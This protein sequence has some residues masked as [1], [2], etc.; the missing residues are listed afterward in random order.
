MKRIRKYPGPTGDTPVSALWK[1][2]KIERVT[3]AEIVEALRGSV[4]AIEEDKLGLKAEQVGTQYQRSEAAMAMYLG[5][6]PVY[7]I[8]MIG[9]WSSDTFLRY[10]RK[11]VEQ[12]SHNVSRRMICFQFHSHIPDLWEWVPTCSA[13]KPNLSSTMAQ[14]VSLRAATIFADVTCSIL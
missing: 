1:N 2:H 10:T 4:C 5:E 8:M 14:T 9:Q 12:F 6:C 11:Q 13:L 7:T 3:S